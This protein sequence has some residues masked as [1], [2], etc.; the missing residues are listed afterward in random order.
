MAANLRQVSRKIWFFLGGG[1]VLFLAC[2][3]SLAA[4]HPQTPANELV[5]RRNAWIFLPS[6]LMAATG[7]YISLRYWRCPHCGAP[8]Q[9]RYP[10]PRNCP[11]CGR[12]VGLI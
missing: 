2:A 3:L 6:L 1:C 11:R 12:D 4:A 8:L 9:T 10:I 7:M 5:T